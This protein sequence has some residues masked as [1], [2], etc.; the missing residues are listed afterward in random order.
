MMPVFL[1][2]TVVI[3]IFAIVFALE[4]TAVVTVTIFTVAYESNLA[5]VLMIALVLG[6]LM[7]ISVIVPR[8][9]KQR[10]VIGNLNKKVKTLEA[11]AQKNVQAPVPATSEA[12]SEVPKTPPPASFMK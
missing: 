5:I 4:N 6:I 12:S 8:M 10:L 1:V 2:L 9:I 11:A 3:A 7:G